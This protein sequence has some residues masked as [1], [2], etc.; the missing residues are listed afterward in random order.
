M[1]GGPEKMPPLPV[2][3]DSSLILSLKIFIDPYSCWGPIWHQK[4]IGVSNE[5]NFRHYLIFE[6]KSLTSLEAE[7]GLVAKETR[8]GMEC[9]EKIRNR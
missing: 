9:N 1:G 3:N 7:H 5:A 8:S 4:G 2:K 6:D